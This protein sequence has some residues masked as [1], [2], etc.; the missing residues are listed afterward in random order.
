MGIVRQ[1]K[2][3]NIIVDIFNNSKN[4]LSVVDLVA[5]LT[6]DMNKTTVYR[7][8]DRL[9]NDGFVHSFTDKDG[10]KWYAKCHDC[11]VHHHSDVHP[12]FQCK[13]CGK[14]ECLNEEI[15]LPHFS[16]HQVDDAEILLLGTCESCLN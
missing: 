11:S 16:N 10:H 15:H 4:A 5:L 2:S 14:I 3:V 8:L 6:T 13:K 1:T 9:E 12:H 7:I